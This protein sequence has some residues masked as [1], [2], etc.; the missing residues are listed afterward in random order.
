MCATTAASFQN[1]ERRILQIADK[2][3]RGPQRGP[4][5]FL[6]VHCQV[7]GHDGAACRAIELPRGSAQISS[8]PGR[9]LLLHLELIPADIAGPCFGAALDRHSGM[10]AAAWG[11]AC[12]LRLASYHLYFEPVR[13]PSHTFEHAVAAYHNT[14]TPSE[15]CTHAN[16]CSSPGRNLF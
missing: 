13:T 6:Q 4:R 16:T 5:Q 3:K 15:A 7:R 14:T 12:V 1:Q 10:R 11:A 8:T 9:P 2:C